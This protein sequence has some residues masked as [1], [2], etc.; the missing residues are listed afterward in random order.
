VQQPARHAAQSGSPDRDTKRHS[1]L[2]LCRRRVLHHVVGARRCLLDRVQHRSGRV[3]DPDHRPIGLG[4]GDRHEKAS[5]GKVEHLHAF[6]RGGPIEP[7]EAQHNA[8]PVRAT[9][10]EGVHAGL[11]VERRA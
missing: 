10:T 3:V 8:A 5:P 9:L 7:A 1:R 2:P 11:G 4:F 6:A